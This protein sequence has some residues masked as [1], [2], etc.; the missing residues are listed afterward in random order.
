MKFIS[1]N[2]R[3]INGPTKHRMIHRNILQENPSIILI[4][5]TKCSSSNL[6]T[7]MAHLW[8]GSMATT[9][10]ANGASGGLENHLESS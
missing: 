9:V 3:G 5:E 8:K 4:Q 10:D 1:W 7:L 2:V 6:E